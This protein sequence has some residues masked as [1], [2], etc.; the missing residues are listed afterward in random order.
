MRQSSASYALAEEF[1]IV[2]FPFEGR[3]REL[4]VAEYDVLVDSGASSKEITKMLL[5]AIEIL[6]NKRKKAK[7]EKEFDSLTSKISDMLGRL[8]VFEEDFL[9]KK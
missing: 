2:P 9:M 5:M 6:L 1:T 3:D 4:I 7:N 8:L